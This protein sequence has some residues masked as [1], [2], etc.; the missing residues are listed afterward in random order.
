VKF[1]LFRS[2]EKNRLVGNRRPVFLMIFVTLYLAILLMSTT[3]I[4]QAKTASFLTGSPASP[5]DVPASGEPVILAP[6]NNA[7]L[8]SPLKIQVITK[9]GEDGLV[10]IELIGQDNRLIFRKLLNYRSYSGKTLLIDQVIPFEIR[11]DETARLQIVLEDKKGKTTFL[12]SVSLNL[13]GL[14]G[15]ES[16]GDPAVN[17][18]FR[19]HQPDITAPIKGKLL[20]LECDI[21]PINNTPV[22][23][24][25]VARDGHTM[26]SRLVQITMP[27]NQLAYVNLIASLPFSVPTPTEV[28]LRIRQDSNN[29]IKG[30]V[31]LWSSKVTLSP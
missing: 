9:P 5:V 13:L 2:Y 6:G 25:L 11:E 31:L 4:V 22:N 27:N 15:R 17:P 1:L 19:I 30:T 24:E 8:I 14:R 21:K 23:I 18:H 7:S 28:T 16:D 10:R 29:L 12:N 26:A 3:N 20:T